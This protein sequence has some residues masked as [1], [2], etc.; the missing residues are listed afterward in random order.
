MY[1]FPSW[2]KK[3]YAFL[4]D[5]EDWWTVLVLDLFAIPA[6]IVLAK[7][8]KY[9]RRITPNGI[10]LVSFVIF[11]LG[12]A[13]LFVYPHAN[14]YFTLCFF[15][16][17]VL[18]AMDGKLA[19]LRGEQ[20]Q[21]GAV[22]D[23]LFDMLKH[24]IGLMLVG[25]AMS[26]KADNV[27]PLIIILPYSLFLGIGNINFITR[28]VTSLHAYGEQ[29]VSNEVGHQTRW[30]LFL[31][32][33]GLASYG[34]WSEVEVIYVVILLIGINLHDPTWFL[35]AG[36]YLSFIPRIWKKFRKKAPKLPIPQANYKM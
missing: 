31:D 8:R 24:S 14:T 32:K 15:L 6:T 19:R 27:C 12:V 17:C 5:N 26:I 4:K 34:P 16:S 3:K 2:R 30:Q 11:Y 10:S 25:C 35:L 18:D 23:Q 33:R 13:L 36:I 1:L 22:V 20:S 29:E 7:L 28:T 21:F 9:F